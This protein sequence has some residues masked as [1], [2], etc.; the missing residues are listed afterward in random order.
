MDG[1]KDS[2]GLFAVAHHPEAVHRV[3]LG[4]HALQHRGANGVDLVSSAGE[5]LTCIRGHGS[6]QQEISGP[7]LQAMM[8]SMALG[9]VHGGAEAVSGAT[10]GDRLAYARYRSGPIAVALSGALTNGAA[11]RQEL[12]KDHALFHSTSDAELLA[13]LVARSGQKTL[14]NRLVDALWKVHGAYSVMVLTPE[15]LVVA[16][17]PRGFRPLWMGRV[18]EDGLIVSSEDGA[19]RAAGGIAERE[20]EPGELLISDARGTHS[21]SPFLKQE[22][23]ACM[24][25]FVQLTGTEGTVFGHAS[26]AVR[27]GLGERLAREAPCENARVV[28]GLPGAGESMAVGYART[29]RLPFEHGLVSGVVQGS[30]VEPPS[31]MAEFGSRLRLRVVTGVVRE[32]VVVLVVPSIS[33]GDG[34]DRVVRMLKE[35]GAAEVHIRVGSAP[36]RTH[37][38]YGV[39]TPTSDELVPRGAAVMGQAHALGV[40]SLVHIS[41]DGMHAVAGKRVDAQSLYCDACMSGNLPVVPEPVDDQLP[42]F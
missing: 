5:F 8:G 7:R 19:I 1:I 12:L 34:S 4:L 38:P 3:Y 35:A 36:L 11:L 32:R 18:G 30:L 22:A 17:D 39:Q 40:E 41:L 15:H 13:L 28:L 2:S 24:Q 10:G 27:A 21:L 9:Q 31:G 23:T 29:A 26:W 20:I 16:R 14:V 42:L 37:C 6:V 33:P 25:E